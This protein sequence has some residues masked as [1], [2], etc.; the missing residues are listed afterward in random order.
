M[1]SLMLRLLSIALLTS[2]ISLFAADKNDGA[3]AN[4]LLFLEKSISV[5]PSYKLE[6]VTILKKEKF[7]RLDG[8]MV[9]FVQIDLNVT[10]QNK[11]ISVNDIIFSD[12][13]IVSKDFLDV[14][15]GKSVKGETSF[16]FNPDDYDEEHLIAGNINAK[17]KIA[18]FSD[19]LCPFCMDYIPSLIKDVEA[20]P[21]SLALF[22]YHFPLSVH[23]GAETIV[24]ASIL[25]E[26]SG[27]KDIT[28][29]VYEEVFE[30]DKKDEQSVLKLFN[31][32]MKTN[33]TISDINQESIL[34]RVQ[35]DEKIANTLMVRGT[36]TVY[37][38]GKKDE[39][40]AMYKKF[41][42]ESR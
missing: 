4:M 11:K 10:K 26:K 32:A 15:S 17:H 41:M 24:K 29:R 19:P 39:T 33:F 40:R 35:K 34:K 13:K 21:E 36:P 16:G 14:L 27:Q 2:S 7:E 25:A 31:N 1:K 37:I 3:D 20:N 30:L 28:K 8:W 6:K 5:N 22:Y 23:V 18:V 42:K 12:G 9:Y 38:D